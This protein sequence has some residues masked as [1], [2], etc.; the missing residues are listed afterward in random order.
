MITIS[1]KF[2]TLYKYWDFLFLTHRYLSKLNK[3]QIDINLDNLSRLMYLFC[4]HSEVLKKIEN[5]HK[6]YW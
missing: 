3:I 2:Y 6:N 1:E 4:L 5:I